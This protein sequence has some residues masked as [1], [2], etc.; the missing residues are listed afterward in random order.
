MEQQVNEQSSP[1]V[2]PQTEE[3][4]SCE[5]DT[6]LEDDVPSE[7]SSLT[8]MYLQACSRIG[9]VP[10]GYFLRH[11]GESSLNL[12]YYGIGP[13]GAKAL[14]TVLQYDS[15][16]T[17]LELEDNSLKAEG[18][19]YVVEMLQLNTT[20][21]SL[22]LSN[23][24]LRVEGAHIISKMLS[25]NLYVKCLRFSGNG[26]D[27]ASAK[28]FADALKGD[29]MI[30]ELDLSHNKFSNTGGEH[31]GQMLAG[32]VAIE[33]LNLS[34]NNLM[35][36]GAEALCA[37]LK[38][39]TT[40][41]HFLLVSNGFS[42]FVADSLSD[43]LKMNSTLV[44]LDLSSN[45]I[46]DNAVSTLCPGLAVNGRLKLHY[47]TITFVGALTLLRTVK[48]NTRTALEDINISTVLVC[49]AFLEL[50]EDVQKKLPALV[51]QYK[52]LP[53][54]TK[55]VSALPLFKKYLKEQR[56][57]LMEAFRAVDKDRTMKISTADFRNVIKSSEIPLD[58]NQ[59]E[60]LVR[61][62]DSQCTA[63]ISYR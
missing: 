17:N 21:N 11:L 10:V 53:H 6:D 5:F 61:K 49:E 31:L 59:I 18:T 58:R 8:D 39:N 63:T 20:I 15:T 25:D 34:W 36:K 42:S 57:N 26:F 13:L 3:E 60:W 44:L 9:T 12:N 47:N 50:L 56:Q 1:E 22:N 43:A 51:I 28:Y 4:G 29:Y 40:L 30:K 16:I 35:M 41:K 24:D 48:I 23:N 33:T 62:F 38:V 54:I 37:G 45:L 19:H 27:D 52:V 14:A 46:Y 7:K 32:N 2:L 55:R